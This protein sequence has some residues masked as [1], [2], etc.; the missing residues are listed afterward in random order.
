MRVNGRN[1]F[2]KQPTIFLTSAWTK[3]DKRPQ[4]N[5]LPPQPT[6]KDSES[7]DNDGREIK[8]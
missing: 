5:G 7:V 3:T 1:G 8:M 6:N 2:I 4:I